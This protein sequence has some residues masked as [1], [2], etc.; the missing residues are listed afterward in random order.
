MANPPQALTESERVVMRHPDAM[1]YYHE[2]RVKSEQSR[3]SL[4]AQRLQ[5]LPS[6]AEKAAALQRKP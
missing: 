1:R 4:Q 5:K 2:L 3:A 6:K